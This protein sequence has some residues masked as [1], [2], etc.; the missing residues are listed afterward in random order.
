[1]TKAAAKAAPK[2]ARAATVP[3]SQTGTVRALTAEATHRM[4]ALSQAAVLVNEIAASAG[5]FGGPLTMAQRCELTL[6]F[7]HWVSTGDI[8]TA[9]LA[10]TISGEPKTENENSGDG[11]DEE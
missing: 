5:V 11:G 2:A 4:S 1:M 8:E 6:A 7:A 9:G 3:K 10:M